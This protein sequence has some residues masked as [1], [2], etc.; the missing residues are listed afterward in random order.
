MTDFDI[1]CYKVQ[2]GT[3]AGLQTRPTR[4][5][6]VYLSPASYE[7]E[8]KTHVETLSRL[9]F[10]LYA[11]ARYALLIVIQGMD[12][13]GKDG[14][15]AHVL[16]GI[17]PEGC[18]VYSF[19]QPSSTELQHDFLWRSNVVLPARG[20]IAIFNRSYYEEVLVVRV[21]PEMLLAEGLSESDVAS[22]DIW[23][24]RFRSINAMERHLSDNGT[25][26]VKLFLHVSLAEQTKRFLERVDTPAKN[27]KLSST[28]IEERKYWCGYGLAY[29]DCLSATSTDEAPWFV[30]PADDKDTARLIASQIIV[31][32]LAKMQS[33]LLKPDKA[34]I[35]ELSAARA[36]LV[37][38]Q[39]VVSTG[40]RD[41]TPE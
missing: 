19:K 30:I 4:V 40:I 22:G 16:S 13:A 1:G 7:T 34:R 33:P 35:A 17:N 9:Q 23:D 27:W 14:T 25:R 32:T 37:A 2:P 11:S 8:L 36:E 39:G 31:N 15:I 6:P 41:F 21:H 38:G 24:K 26:I 29:E 3:P 12:A 18:D 5:A 20:K 10:N 28:D